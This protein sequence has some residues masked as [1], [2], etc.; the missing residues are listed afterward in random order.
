MLR[1]VEVAEAAPVERTVTLV[2]PTGIRIEGVT[3]A[4]VIVILRGLT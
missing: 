3:I 2:S 1:R 4:E